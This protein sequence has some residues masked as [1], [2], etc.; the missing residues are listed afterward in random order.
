MLSHGQGP[1]P[2]VFADNSDIVVWNDAGAP[3]NWLIAID[4]YVEIPLLR[5]LS[6]A[7][8]GAVGVTCTNPQ[9]G[10]SG[11]DVL[12]PLPSGATHEVNDIGLL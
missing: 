12:L 1:D 6:A 11:R 4:D 8:D 10:S 5:L 9:R 2:S 3:A 7:G